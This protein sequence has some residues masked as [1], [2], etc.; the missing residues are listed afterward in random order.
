MNYCKLPYFQYRTDLCAIDIGDNLLLQLFCMFYNWILEFFMFCKFLLVLITS[1]CY[2]N[3]CHALLLLNCSCSQALIAV[4]YLVVVSANCRKY[5]IRRGQAATN[6]CNFFYFLC[7]FISY[8]TEK[9]FA[10]PCSTKLWI[11]YF[12]FWFITVVS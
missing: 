4:Y 5:W 12:A 2:S 1:Q 6:N 10:K 11:F 8:K 3:L 9:H 7:T